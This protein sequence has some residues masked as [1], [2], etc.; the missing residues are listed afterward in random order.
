METIT[1]IVDT[2]FNVVK[3]VLSPLG[4]LGGFLDGISTALKGSSVL[5]STAE[6]A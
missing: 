4:G 2:V 6:N 1:I 5:S 3:A